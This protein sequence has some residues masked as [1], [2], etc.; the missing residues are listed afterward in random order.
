MSWKDASHRSAKSSILVSSTAFCA[1]LYAISCYLTAFIVS[2]W[3]RGQFRPA[4]V[5]PATFAIAFGPLP[6]ALGA[7]I[8]TFVAD[9]IKHGGPY[10][11]S[12]VAAVPGNFVGFYL[13]GRLVERKFDWKRFLVASYFSL[14]VGNLIVAFL[15]VPTI[16]YLGFLP[17]TLTASDLLLFAFGLFIWFFI[18]EYPFVLLILPPV[19]VSLV[20]AGK[21]MLS[22]PEREVDISL[23][24]AYDKASI[25]LLIPGACFVFI[26]IFLASTPLGEP[27]VI[28][29][30]KGFSLKLGEEL[31]K[32]FSK[33][34]MVAIEVMF[35][36]SGY[37]MALAGAIIS[38]VGSRRKRN[39]SS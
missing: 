32:E 27:I 5:V 15:Y 28:A 2:P 30:E 25:W 7:A 4:V 9:S 20:K 16:Y 22:S 18:T 38:I 36:V 11:P 34:T 8:G 13:F 12:L 17:E 1:A 35:I 39:E 19:I 6:A 10:I 21:V 26:G 33:A 24:T 14:L 23:K 31:A 37:A 29:F 3:G